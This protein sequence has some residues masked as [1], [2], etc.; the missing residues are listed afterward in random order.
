V[1]V[2]L[3]AEAPVKAPPI[4]EAGPLAQPKPLD[5]AGFPAELTRQA[6]PP[7]NPQTPEKIALGE[8]AR[9]GARKPTAT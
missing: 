8:T 1:A 2:V 3:A 9:D 5:Q 6:I 4:P 7:D